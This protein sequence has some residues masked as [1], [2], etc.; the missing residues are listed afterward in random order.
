MRTKTVLMICPFASPN[1]GGVEAH[2]DKLIDK[3]LALGHNIVLIS[4]QPLTTRAKGAPYEKRGNLEIYRVSWFGYNLFHKLEPYFFATFFYLF[5]GLF[6]KSLGFYLKKYKEIDVIHAHGLTAALIARILCKIHR[7]RIVLSTHAVYDF[8]QRKTLSVLVKVILQGFDKVLAVGEMSKRELH[9]IG[10]PMEKLEIHPNWIDVRRFAPMDKADC[11]KK[12][13]LEDGMFAALYLGR[14]IEQ[15]G[16]R[17]LVG[18]AKSFD[19]GAA[20][21]FCGDGPLADYVRD[22]SRLAKNI[23]FKGRLAAEEL[24]VYYN[25]ADLFVLPSQYNEGFATVILEAIA[26]GTPVLVTNRGCV[27][28]YVDDTVGDLID[29]T[30]ENIQQKIKSYLDAPEILRKKALACRPY[31]EKHFSEKNFEV[32]LKSYD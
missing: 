3:L 4:Y 23:V 9:A 32:I 19:G 2:L 28:W 11:R 12:A 7:K 1:I 15:K 16:V 21:L 17:E 30:K 25:A 13:G 22:E 8:G 26:C 5:P 27:P 10:L 6:F 31:A 14:L 20:F 24:P 18:A 29:P